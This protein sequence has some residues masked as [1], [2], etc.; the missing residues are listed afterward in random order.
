[1]NEKPWNLKQRNIL[2]SETDHGWLG[3]WDSLSLHSDTAQEWD[4]M[5]DVGTVCR[6]MQ[7]VFVGVHGSVQVALYAAS[8]DTFDPWTV[9]EPAFAPHFVWAANDLKFP[10]FN[11]FSIKTC[12]LQS[13]VLSMWNAQ[14]SA[15]FSRCWCGGG[16]AILHICYCMLLASTFAFAASG[17]ESLQKTGSKAGLP[18]LKLL[19]HVNHVNCL[20]AYSL[21]KF[22]HPFSYSIFPGHRVLSVHIVIG[23]NA[24][25]YHPDVDPSKE[26]YAFASSDSSLRQWH[27]ERVTSGTH[28]I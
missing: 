14:G 25:R 7:C 11:G 26:A 23:M 9:R 20:L 1:M 18:V 8:S 17:K 15:D 5:S 6:C 12:F 2:D 19:T 10:I 4:R 28:C 27:C 16:T 24:A 21:I 3:P 13:R 22:H